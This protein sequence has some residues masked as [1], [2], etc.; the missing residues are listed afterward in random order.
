MSSPLSLRNLGIVTF[1]VY[2]SLFLSPPNA[3]PLLFSTNPIREGRNRIIEA[4][5]IEVTDR[6]VEESGGEKAQRGVRPGVRV[7]SR[8]GFCR[9]DRSQ[10]SETFRAQRAIRPKETQRSAFFPNLIVRS[11]AKLR[12]ARI[13]PRLTGTRRLIDARMRFE[14]A[15]VMGKKRR[16]SERE[17][18][19]EGERRDTSY[20]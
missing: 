7:E 2:L 4:G 5:I 19:R 16:A 6:A 15:N 1:S 13:S 3:R 20:P 8:G 12:R 10:E 18:E 17:R 14:I 11:L 9:V